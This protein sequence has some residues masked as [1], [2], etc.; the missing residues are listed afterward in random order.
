MGPVVVEAADTTYLHLTSLMQVRVL[1]G[2]QVSGSYQLVI[3]FP[4]PS[5]AVVNLQFLY[6]HKINS[7]I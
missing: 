5:Y 6:F 3:S 1:G 7:E 2:S 4:I